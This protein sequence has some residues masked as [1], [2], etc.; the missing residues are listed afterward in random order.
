MLSHRIFPIEF[1]QIVEKSK[2]VD[3]VLIR[4]VFIGL[5]DLG[6]TDVFVVSKMEIKVMYLFGH[7]T[8]TRL[9]RVRV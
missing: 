2:E 9:E 8:F 7:L 6:R 4:K 1:L 3:G 5:V